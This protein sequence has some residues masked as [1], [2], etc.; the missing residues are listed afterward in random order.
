MA[1]KHKDIT[2]NSIT[3]AI[4]TATVA[5]SFVGDL[6]SK[7][8][9][10]FGT[11]S[12]SVVVEQSPDNA[13]WYQ[14]G[15]KL[16]ASGYRELDTNAQWV[17]IRSTAHSSGTVQAVCGGQQRASDPARFSATSMG[18]ITSSLATDAVTVHNLEDATIWVNMP[19]GCTTVAQYSGDGTY[20]QAVSGVASTGTATVGTAV[21]SLPSHCKQARV[22][23][24]AGTASTQ[25][26]LTG[27]DLRAGKWQ[28]KTT[29][30][31]TASGSTTVYDLTEFRAARAYCNYHTTG[32]SA[33]VVIYGRPGAGTDWYEVTSQLTAQGS[34][35]LPAWVKEAKG[36]VLGWSAS[37]LSFVFAENKG[38]RTDSGY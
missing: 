28:S 24:T 29:S 11:F 27:Q 37:S 16:A 10:V 36:V 4:S 33:T 23:C 14:V 18:S 32:A 15:A 34:R 9:G 6:E 35:V 20:W 19:S 7:A 26:Y 21:W 12:A 38:E 5:G 8:V 17:R 1:N 13:K 3:S 25:V 30:T 31:L 22:N 2:L